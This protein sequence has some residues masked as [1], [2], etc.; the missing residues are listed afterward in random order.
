MTF[1]NNSVNLNMNCA[2]HAN[3]EQSIPTYQ[4]TIIILTLSMQNDFS[5]S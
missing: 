5:T 4:Q 2:T 1:K 3:S